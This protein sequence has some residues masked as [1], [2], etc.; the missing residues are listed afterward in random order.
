MIGKHGK[1]LT[2]C[3]KTGTLLVS[4][5]S[6]YGRAFAGSCGPSPGGGFYTCSG[7]VAPG[8]ATATR[9]TLIPMTMTTLPGFGISTGGGR[10]FDLTAIGGLTFTDTN[11]SMI[12]GATDGIF[13]WNSGS[14]ALSITASG[15]VTGGGGRGI[16]ATNYGIDLTISATDVSGGTHGIFAWNWGSGALTI[17]AADVSGGTVGIQALNAGSGALL[18]TASGA[19]TGSGGRGIDAINNNGTDLI[20]SAADVSGGTDGIS[21]INFFSDALSIT[22]SGAVTGGGGRGIYARNLYGTDLTIS[23]TDVSGGTDGIFASNSGSGALSITASGAV[24]GS[25]GRGIYARNIGTDLTISAADVSGGTDGIFA[26]NLGSGALSI[27]ASGAVTGGGGRGIYAVN[28]GTDLTISAADVSGGTDGIFARN[29]GSGALSITTGGTVR[30]TSGHG[31]YAL[32]NGGLPT[33]I[34]VGPQSI[35]TGGSSGITV[36]SGS[37]QPALVDVY[38]QVGN[39]SGSNA[40]RAIAIGGGPATVNL[41]EG[42]ITTGL[43]TTDGYDD[44]VTLNGSLNGSLYMYDGNDTLIQTGGSVLTGTADGG[45]GTDTLGFDNMGTADSG[46]YLNFENLAILGG[47]TTLIGTWDFSTGTTIYQGNLYVNGELLTSLLTVEKGGLLGGSGHI[48][49]DVTVFGTVSPGN[50]IGTL[51]V[52]GS[53]AFM[54][55][56]TY[57]AQLGADDD[58]DLLRVNGPATIDGSRLRT[59]LE[60]GLYTDGERWRIISATGGIGGRFSSVSTNFTS[61]TVDLTPAYGGNGLDLVIVRTPYES[62][63]GTAN[64]AAVGAALDAILPLAQGAMAGLLTAMDFDLDAAGI[65]ATLT[66]LNPEMYT[67]FPTAGL[68]VAGNF[69]EIVALRQQEARNAAYFT[70][71]QDHSWNVWARAFGDWLDREAEN[72][73]SGYTLDTSGMVFGLDRAF[74]SA[75]RAGGEL[76]YSSS[77]LSQDTDGQGH[78]D[79]KHIGVYA[80]TRH[81]GFYLDGSAG[82]TRLDEN[83]ERA[84]ATP[85]FTARA[86]SGFN[87]DVL[88]GT[89]LGGYDFTFGPVRLGPVAAVNYRHLDQDSVSE[90]GAGDFAIEIA[91]ETAESL[92]STLSLRATGLFQKADWRFLPRAGVGLEHQFKDDPVRLTANFAGYPEANFTVAGA[93]PP[94]NQVLASLGMSTEYGRNLSLYLDLSAALASDQEDT[95]LTGG[96]EWKF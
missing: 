41:R 82:Y 28:N 3:L 26:R 56:S 35:V 62:F 36:N 7:A 40:D 64:E 93:E 67:A 81:G 24:T 4:L 17:S 63:G 22:A 70:E 27:T 42:S 13:A 47:S 55:G 76:G 11:A 38:G 19:V 10:A 15:A 21:A 29:L 80:G 91:S 50:S 88:D 69:S 32:N 20:I 79:G 37:G 48:F 30:G 94:K 86:A 49:G 9:S 6:G 92:T 51:D 12:T 14:G 33:T 74:F 31:I 61:A 52:T 34:T 96:L 23:A 8:D 66:G 45:S 71:E 60:R 83:A 77:D 25:G 39:L 90:R 84:I 68:S 1:A 2:L 65:S 57:V 75:G 59:S 89:L 16:W 43:V 58:S 78:I 5:S 46:H 53:V 85:I 72:G 95:L 18:I 87:A 54:P 73:V 44:T